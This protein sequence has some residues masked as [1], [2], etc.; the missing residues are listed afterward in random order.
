MNGDINLY[1]NGSGLVKISGDSIT[2]GSMTAANLML[3][4]A[5]PSGESAAGTAGEIRVSGN[6]LFLYN[7]STSKWRK[8]T[9]SEWS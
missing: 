2:T 9:I 4:K 8:Q 3:N 1:C 7:A 5:A 6:Y